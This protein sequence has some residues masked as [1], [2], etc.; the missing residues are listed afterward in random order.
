M[1]ISFST[2]GLYP[3]KSIDALKLIEQAGFAEAELMPQCLTETRPEFARE[4]ARL[5][6]RVSSIHFPLVLF[7][8]YYNPY[9]LMMDECRA[10]IDDLVEAGRIM[11]TEIIVIHPFPSMEGFRKELFE[12]PVMENLRYLCEKGKTAGITIALENNPHGEGR[13]PEE[14]LKAVERVENNNIKP[15]VDT[16]EAWEA[17]IEPS[18]FISKVPVVHLH[19]S[20]HEDDIKHLPPGDGISNWDK[21]IE[22]VK[23]QEYKGIHVIEPAYRYYLEEPIE[24]LRKAREFIEAF[25][26]NKPKN[27]L[28]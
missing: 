15:M 5:N 27:A 17:D 26:V 4:V 11:G 2:A 6:L 14:L 12:K 25:E 23:A 13:T 21:I 1:R 3:R 18:E 28:D 7:S 24:K 22:S 19:L 16:T 10:L 20:D 9:P 8:M